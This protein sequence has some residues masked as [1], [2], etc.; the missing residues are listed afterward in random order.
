[1]LEDYP[2][3]YEIFNSVTECLNEYYDFD[4]ENEILDYV[5][6]VA[7]YSEEAK[8]PVF[9]VLTKGNNPLSMAIDKT[10]KEGYTHSSMSFNTRLSP[11]YSFGTNRVS[12]GKIANGMAMGLGFS[13]SNPSSPF[14]GSKPVPYS[15]FVFF[16][17]SEQ[18][19][20][21]KERIKYFRQNKEKM[22]YSMVGLVKLLLKV[23]NEAQYKWFCSQFVASV[24][25]AGDMKLSKPESQHTPGDIIKITDF[26]L[27]GKGN[28]IHKPN[29]KQIEDNVQKIID[30]EDAKIEEKKEE[31]KEPKKEDNDVKDK[32]EDKSKD[33]NDKEKDNDK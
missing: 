27:V 30:G 31:E 16:V 14:W 10:I 6:E 18:R 19:T 1:M 11:M 13:V 12:E 33:N 24:L 8:Y 7:G 29:Y 28:D 5:N 9:I 25:K 15:V 32:E 22:K 17:T 4:R 2:K 3:I 20:K 26:V 23:K 21:M